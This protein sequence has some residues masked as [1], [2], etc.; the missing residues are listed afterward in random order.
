MTERPSRNSEH[1]ATCISA[2]CVQNLI[3]SND[4][5]SRD[6]DSPILPIEFGVG[7]DDGQR[8][9]LDPGLVGHKCLQAAEAEKVTEASRDV[10]VI[11]VQS[12][13]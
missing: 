12:S 9:N 10:G 13:E 5:I 3:S 7:R 11:P 1:Y 2:S 6:L 8:T 4:Q